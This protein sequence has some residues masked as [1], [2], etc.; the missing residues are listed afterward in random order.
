MNIFARELVAIL[1]QH[2]RELSN[3]FG[4]RGNGIQILPS[5][6][7]RL[8]RSLSE[9]ITAT[10]N[11]DELELL[12][13]WAPLDDDGSEMRRLRAAL[14]AEGVHHL[15]AGRME[16][17]NAQRMGELALALLLAEDGAEAKRLGDAILQN[18]RGGLAP[19]SSARG[20]LR[21]IPDDTLPP[22][23]VEADAERTIERALDPPT[24]AYA[25]GAL[26]LEIARDTENRSEQLGYLALAR[27]LLA[28]AR[29]LAAG[30]PSYAEGTQLTELSA[31]ITAAEADIDLLG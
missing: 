25:Q 15:L 13:D 16:L 9:D 22:P 18:V 29:T 24:E 7:T 3:L 1:G 4:L 20:A 14:L 10:L 11:A 26:W 28:R 30:V 23:D 5:K 21:G 19:S 12:Q 31:A 2:H 8:K 27:T 17:T 6:V